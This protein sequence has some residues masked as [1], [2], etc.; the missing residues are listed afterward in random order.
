MNC[1]LFKVRQTHV[2]CTVGY[3][4]DIRKERWKMRKFLTRNLSWDAAGLLFKLIHEKTELENHVSDFL[5]VGKVFIHTTY[6]RRIR[7]GL[8][9][10]RSMNRILTSLSGLPI[11]CNRK[12]SF[13]NILILLNWFLMHISRI[14]LA[15]F[16]IKYSGNRRQFKSSAPCRPFHE[17][18]PKYSAAGLFYEIHKVLWIQAF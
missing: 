15:N 18:T 9:Q 14:S 1:F 2:H 16:T 5:W 4:R 8:F 11:P 10:F 7:H 3:S 6:I 13:L 12:N 17:T